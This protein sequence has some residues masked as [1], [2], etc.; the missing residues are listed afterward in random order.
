MIRKLFEMPYN[1]YLYDWFYLIK[2]KWHNLSKLNLMYLLDVT[3]NH[4]IHG[5]C[6]YKTCLRYIDD[7][8][9]KIFLQSKC[10]QLDDLFTD[11][12]SNFSYKTLEFGSICTEDLKKTQ[13]DRIKIYEKNYEIQKSKNLYRRDDDFLRRVVEKY[14]NYK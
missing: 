5:L 1:I 10:G 9:Y 8:T 3:S 13:E 11:Y 12:G 14:K 2:K 4:H 6:A 7:K